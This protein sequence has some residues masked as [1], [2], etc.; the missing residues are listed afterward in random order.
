[1]ARTLH[2]LAA[3]GLAKLPP[4]LHGDGGG[5]WLQVRP[6]GRSWLFRFMIGGKARAMGLGGFPAVSLQ[7]ARIAAREARDLLRDG[8]DPL[9]RKGAVRSRRANR[10][11][12]EQ[13]VHRCI[14]DRQ[15]QWQNGKH[16][17]QWTS[18]L[19]T[20]CGVFAQAP[21]SDI[22][23]DMV[24]Q[25]LKPIWSRKTETACRTRMR[26]EAV[27]NWAMAHGY[28]E[29]G[30][31][32][33]R[34]KGHLDQVLPNPSKIRNITHFA[35][36]DYRELPVF[37]AELYEK[38]SAARR[39]LAFLILTASRVSEVTGA[40]WGEI[41]LQGNVWTIPGARMKRG[42]EHRVPLAPQAAALL[43]R[44][45]EFTSENTL[46]PSPFGG[47]LSDTSIRRVLQEQLGR[48]ELT[49]HGF[50]SSFRDW[51]AE[52]TDVP[53]EIA[54]R[55]LAHTIGS[56]TER[57]YRRGDLLEKRRPLMEQWASFC[58]QRLRRL[59]AVDGNTHHDYP[60]NI[61]ATEHRNAQEEIRAAHA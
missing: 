26:I 61:R 9:T 34:W 29:P 4:G 48:A 60:Q 21:V 46:F 19:C 44:E 14:E 30:L 51:C 40:T 31:N 28:R 23:A 54:E 13:A 16:A 15:A 27:L 25:A 52:E 43:K 22:D 55:S 58:S 20:Y 24:L 41:D 39:A 3:T 32:P 11:T 17:A 7:Q 59:H 57:A 47:V 8:V 6:Q 53:S 45:A 42:P 10:L 2:K 37:F 33:A 18:T 49:V 35:A 12:F 56:R 5:L 1:M 36:I 50:R 38:E